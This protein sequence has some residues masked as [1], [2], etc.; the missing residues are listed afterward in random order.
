M[1]AEDLDALQPVG[2]VRVGL[3][4]EDQVV[5]VAG[6]QELIVRAHG[7]GVDHGLVAFG[8]LVLLLDQLLV[9]R[10]DV[11]N[12]LGSAVALD[13]P[14]GDAAIFGSCEQVFAVRRFH[15]TGQ[16]FLVNFVGIVS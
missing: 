6:G 16:A 8:G 1:P 15:N 11:G 10:L 7:H 14:F 13:P 9:G 2:I 3:P 5:V 4:N 12:H